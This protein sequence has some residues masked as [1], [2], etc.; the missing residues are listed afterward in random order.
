MPF[1]VLEFA[2]WQYLIDFPP[3]FPR[4]SLEIDTKHTKFYINTIYLGTI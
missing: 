3:H 2:F 1:Q 4:K